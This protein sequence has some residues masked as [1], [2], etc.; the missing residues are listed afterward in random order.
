MRKFTEFTVFIVIILS[1]HFLVKIT[2][3]VLLK[4]NNK[5]INR[6]TNGIEGKFREA[7]NSAQI[8]SNNK[9]KS[10]TLLQVPYKDNTSCKAYIE[11]SKSAMY[12]EFNN[13]TCDITKRVKFIKE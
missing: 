2:Y 11:T 5:L 4:S 9:I 13:T 3:P 6:Y 7:I 8:N 1:S 10:N 12:L